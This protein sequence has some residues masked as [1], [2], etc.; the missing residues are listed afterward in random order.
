MITKKEFFLLSIMMAV[1]SVNTLW[2]MQSD[3]GQKQQQG[4]QD[5][6]DSQGQEEN[7]NDQN[8][9]EHV[10]FDEKYEDV[11]TSFFKQKTKASEASQKLQEE[12][13]GL[14]GHTKRA[15]VN[16]MVDMGGN[17]LDAGAR[18]AFYEAR[19][20]SGFLTEEEELQQNL[21]KEILKTKEA[22]RELT[23]ATKR[24]KQ[25]EKDFY[26]SQKTNVD[27]ESAL[28]LCSCLPGGFDNPDCQN[29]LKS[30]WNKI[31]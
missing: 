31:N 14:S 24:T 29:K 11:K 21:N 4:Q 22:E 6:N 9:N 18:T 20:R 1:F 5:Q 10:S 12:I 17:W 3:Q 30:F 26:E 2:C 7:K 8:N 19:K 23:L 13:N 15:V 25:S 28:K 16:K 27:I